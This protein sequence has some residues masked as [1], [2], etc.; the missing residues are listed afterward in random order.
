MNIIIHIGLT[1]TGSTALQRFCDNNAEY[2]IKLGYYYLLFE[3][4]DEGNYRSSGNG[5]GL[6]SEV[7]ANA[8]NPVKLQKNYCQLVRSAS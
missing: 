2:L 1:K 6:Y 7:L 8:L 5:F 4:I 3:S